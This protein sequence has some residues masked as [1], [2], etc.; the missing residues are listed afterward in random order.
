MKTAYQLN[1]VD[2][3]RVIFTFVAFSHDVRRRKFQIK[4]RKGFVTP[5][6]SQHFTR[7]SYKLSHEANSKTPLL[8]FHD[9]IS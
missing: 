2:T 6:E 5:V 8:H 1:E 3:F 4:L 9:E 7:L